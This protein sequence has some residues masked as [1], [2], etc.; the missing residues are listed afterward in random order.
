MTDALLWLLLAVVMYF[1]GRYDFK[2][3]LE[4][5]VYDVEFLEAHRMRLTLVSRKKR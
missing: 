2:A 5:G 4:S 3:E 1:A